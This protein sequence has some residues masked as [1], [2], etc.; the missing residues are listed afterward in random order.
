MELNS[1]TLSTKNSF[2]FMYNP[3]RQQA[4]V[5]FACWAWW[6]QKITMKGMHPQKIILIRQNTTNGMFKLL[7][8]C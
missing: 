1:I 2:K 7:L 5:S 4:D 3:F 8:Y 6:G